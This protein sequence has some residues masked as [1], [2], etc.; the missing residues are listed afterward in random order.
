MASSSIPCELLS[1]RS[2]SGHLVFIYQ[3]RN[4]R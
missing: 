2:I 4:V 1:A 3:E